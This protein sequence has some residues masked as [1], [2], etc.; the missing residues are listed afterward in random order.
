MKKI[1]L[2]AVFIVALLASVGSVSA[3][4]LIANGGFESPVV[5]PGNP[6]N[7]G[8]WQIF[9]DGTPGLVWNVQDGIG[10]YD[11]SVPTAVEYQTAGTLGLTPSEGNQYA[12]LDSY[13]NVNIS[14]VFATEQGAIYQVSYA[15]AC[16][17]DGGEQP[18]IL[19]VY[20]DNTKL[21]TTICSPPMQWTTHTAV[22]T[23]TGGDMTLKF[24]DEGTSNSYGALLDAVSVEKIDG[25]VPAPEFPSVFLPVTFIIGFLGAV[26]LVQR[27]RN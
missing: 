21:S 3:A 6:Y 16:R 26:L 8:S 15:Q 2:T 10:G 17:A 14:Q 9:P 20:L 7:M 18:G 11:N 19:G 25:P 24:A 12:E 13:G 5:T 27:T 22:V 23:G 4:N 1:I